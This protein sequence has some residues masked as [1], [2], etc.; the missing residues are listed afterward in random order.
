MCRFLLEQPGG[1]TAQWFPRL[2]A[3]FQQTTVHKCRI[4]G[5]AYSNDEDKGKSTRKAHELFSND[6]RMLMELSTAASHLS[7][8]ELQ[9]LSGELVKKR[10][11]EDGSTDWSGNDN[12]RNSQ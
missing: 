10:K 11:R 9:K 6:R 12:L 5:G 4:W 3:M 2:E 1:S 8:G 7:G